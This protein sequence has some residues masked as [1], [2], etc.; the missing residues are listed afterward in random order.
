MQRRSIRRVLQLSLLQLTLTL[1]A[2]ALLQTE[3]V[4]PQAVRHH[5]RV[6]T[7]AVRHEAG[8]QAPRFETR[9]LEGQE[10]TNASLEGSVTLLQFWTTRCPRCAADQAAVDEIDRKFIGQ[11]LV[12]LAIDAGESAS[13]VGKYLQEH[14]RTC[15][16]ALDEKKGLARRFAVPSYPYYVVIDRQGR[17]AAAEPGKAG[18]KGLLL[19]LSIAGLQPRT[20]QV[21]G[22]TMNPTAPRN[23]NTPN[24]PAEA[25]ASEAPRPPSGMKVIEVPLEPHAR[26]AKPLPKTVFVLTSGER[27]ESDQYTLDAHSLRVAVDGRERTIPTSAL[28]VNA[29]ESANRAR[30]VELKFPTHKNE[31]FVS[32]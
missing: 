28:D 25:N 17:I 21:A 12:V 22:G 4:Q 19:L 30:G 24:A 8:Q 20:Q 26:P 29:T 14:P 23:P 31:V 3:A 7:G 11:G 27:F 1:A 16:V 18:E 15:R 10:F 32:F 13:T 2:S 6:R 5:R 9:T